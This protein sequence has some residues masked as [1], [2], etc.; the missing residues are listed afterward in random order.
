MSR[1]SGCGCG[2]ETS[3]STCSK[4]KLSTPVHLDMDLSDFT[5][6]LYYKLDRVNCADPHSDLSLRRITSTFVLLSVLFQILRS[7]QVSG[8]SIECK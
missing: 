5:C 3:S 4:I 1:G 6:R 2:L 8:L 7:G